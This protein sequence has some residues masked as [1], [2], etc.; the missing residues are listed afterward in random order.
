MAKPISFTNH[1]KKLKELIPADWKPRKI[2]EAQRAKLRESLDKFPE[3]EVPVI[4]TDG[5]IV[6]GHQ[7]FIRITGQTVTHAETG[8]EFA[9]R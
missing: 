9:V 1:R 3:A 6:A 7:R 8:E 5:L 2:S 4:N